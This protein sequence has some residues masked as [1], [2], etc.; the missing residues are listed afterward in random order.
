MS[1][2]DIMTNLGMLIMFLTFIVLFVLL[3][4]PNYG[5]FEYKDYNNNV[6]YANQCYTSTVILYV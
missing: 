2:K 3:L 5:V 1:F 6:G 4:S